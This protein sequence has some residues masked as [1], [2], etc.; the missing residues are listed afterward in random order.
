MTILNL[1]AILAHGFCLRT[2][3]LAMERSDRSNLLAN[4]SPHYVRDDNLYYA[5]N[6]KNQDG[7][8]AQGFSP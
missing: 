8:E 3:S 1:A 7:R 6:D 2:L 5:R 4:R